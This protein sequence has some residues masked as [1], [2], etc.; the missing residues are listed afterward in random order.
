MS[1]NRLDFGLFQI[2]V[3]PSFD[4][5]RSTT[6]LE[7]CCFKF[8]PVLK[9]NPQVEEYLIKAHGAEHFARSTSDAVNEKS[10]SVTKEAGLG[11]STDNVNLQGTDTVVDSDKLPQQNG[12]L[13]NASGDK[14]SEEQIFIRGSGPHNID[15][16]HAL[17]KPPKE[18]MVSREMCG[19]CAL[20]VLWHVFWVLWLAVLMAYVVAISM[21]VE[22]PCPDGG[23]GVNMNRET[24]TALQGF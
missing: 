2:T 8:N 16:C 10:H 14:C 7:R 3:A 22:Q 18:V 20:R 19:G 5:R 4:E 11:D 1:M 6:F 13:I 21:A 17:D 15:S 24:G 9:W 12:S 23:W